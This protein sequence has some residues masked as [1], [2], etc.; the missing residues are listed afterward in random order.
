MVFK[1][2]RERDKLALYCLNVQRLKNL[3]THLWRV[4]EA[5]SIICLMVK[6][7]HKCLIMPLNKAGASFCS[8]KYTIVIQHKKKNQEHVETVVG[9][10]K[11]KGGREEVLSTSTEDSR[12]EKAGECA[13]KVNTSKT[14]VQRSKMKSTPELKIYDKKWL[15]QRQD[16]SEHVNLPSEDEKVQ[17]KT[18]GGEMLQIVLPYKGFQPNKE[19]ASIFMTRA[20]PR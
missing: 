18:W 16:Y 2:H 7:L 14:K 9:V 13:R 12:K 15:S 17:E 10:A 19:K 8:V 20:R 11:I 1:T 4:W 3:V 6:G 5:L